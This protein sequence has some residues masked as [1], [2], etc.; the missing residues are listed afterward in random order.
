MSWG[1]HGHESQG[2]HGSSDSSNA[3]WECMF[4]YCKEVSGAAHG[5]TSMFNFAFLGIFGWGGGWGGHDSHGHH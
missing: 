5:I 1:G 3:M 2:W 4:G